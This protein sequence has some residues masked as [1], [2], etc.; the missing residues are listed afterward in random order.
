MSKPWKPQI[1]IL[2]VLFVAAVG[3]GR[4]WMQHSQAL[5]YQTDNKTT[6]ALLDFARKGPGR[7]RLAELT[8]FAW[9][10]VYYFPAGT[11]YAEVTT[12]LGIDLFSGKAGHVDERGPLLV[13]QKDA[14][15]VEAVAILP[16]LSLSS[17]DRAL[18]SASVRVRAQD[19]GGRLMLV[20]E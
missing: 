16:P 14:K 18:H 10:T 11:R 4:L 20:L 5:P 3:L 17:P 13:F 12:A 7:T 6:R 9:Q 15:V 19:D 2:L 8:A 1:L